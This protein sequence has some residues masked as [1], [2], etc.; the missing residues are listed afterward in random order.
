MAWLMFRSSFPFGLMPWPV[1]DA[2]VRRVVK[3][4]VH[5]QWMGVAIS[6]RVPA[7]LHQHFGREPTDGDPRNQPNG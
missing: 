5:S 6:N 4:T 2:D 3:G 7:N 1:A